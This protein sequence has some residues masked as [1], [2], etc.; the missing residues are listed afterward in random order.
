M[1]KLDK[2][3]DDSELE[4][5][6]VK[7]RL[8]RIKEQVRAYEELNDELALLVEPDDEQ[9]AE[10]ES[11]QNRFYAIATKVEVIVSPITPLSVSRLNSTSLPT[12]GTRRLK[13]PVADLPKF[14][15]DLEKWLSF[16]NMFLAMI[17]S[18][19]D[20]T[21]LQ[22]FIYVKNCLEDDTLNKILVYDISEENYE[23]AWKLFLDSYDKT[24]IL[25]VK[26]LAAI[27]ELPVQTKATHQGLTRLI[28]DMRQHLNMLASMNVKPDEHLL[29]RILKCALPHNIRSKWEETLSLDISPTLDQLYKFISET[30]FRLFTIEQDSSRSKQE[31]N[32]KRPFFGKAQD[33]AKIRRGEDGAR[34]LM[35][36]TSSNCLVC[37]RENHFIY[38]CREF[39]N[40][41]V[42]QRW[43][44]VKKSNLCKNCLRTHSGKCNSW[45]CKNCRR[46]HNILLHNEASTATASRDSRKSDNVT[47]SRSE[48]NSE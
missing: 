26:H 30:A 11:L 41:T 1:T 10:F 3:A 19:E 2:I 22:K 21:N 28:D 44:F 29:V 32:K 5:A 17:N 4:P 23:T 6:N 45:H 13:L 40:M 14:K 47:D 12:D 37:K 46:F 33:G 31:A 48:V 16:K 43:D 42:Q 7:M 38:Q 34:T 20:I 35:T 24:R 8:D 25:I 9:L 18:R 39:Q 15:G 27:L 36:G